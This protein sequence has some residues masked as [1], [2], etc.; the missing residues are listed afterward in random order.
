[1]DK[2]IISIYIPGE[3]H[4]KVKVHA[5]ENGKAIGDVIT[6]AL[7]LYFRSYEKRQ[8]KKVR[9]QAAGA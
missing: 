3:L 2:K 1:M 4:T 6:K 5:A 7:T 9:E 8:A